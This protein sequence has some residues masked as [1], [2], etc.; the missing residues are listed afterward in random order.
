[1]EPP[2]PAMGSINIE[3]YASPIAV[4]NRIPL[5]YYFRIAGSLLQQANIY[6]NE[7]NHLDLYVALLRY[8][9]LLCETIPKHRDYHAFRSKEKE[10]FTKLIDVLDELESLKPALQQ[11]VAEYNR[12]GTVVTN[13]L[14][15]TYATTREVEKHTP[16]LYGTQ[17]HAD[18][19]NGL[20]QNSLGGRHQ[21]TLLPNVQPDRQFRKQLMNP[22]YPKEEGIIAFL[23]LVC[24]SIAIL[25]LL[26]QLCDFTFGF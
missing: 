25:P 22:P 3:E 9:S 23:P 13:N 11:Q 7:K 8:S 12:G 18:S 6:R 20:P 14:N 21:A 19:T 24:I 1:M 2:Q 15:G 17:P 10:F 26:F 5:P 4:D 16:S